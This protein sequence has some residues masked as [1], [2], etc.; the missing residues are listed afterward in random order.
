[1]LIYQEFLALNTNEELA[2]FNPRERLR[3]AVHEIIIRLKDQ[4]II[5]F[6]EM[7]RI[8][9]EEFKID[10]T[11]EILKNIFDRWDSFNNPD[12]SIFKKSDKNWMDVWVFQGHVK[13]KIKD[14]QIFGKHRKKDYTPPNYKNGEYSGGRYERGV[15]IPNKRPGYHND[16]YY[17]DYYGD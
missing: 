14:K 8:L 6:K 12:Y 16:N 5:K 9:R 11:E 3:Y 1:M 15:W 17:G 7:S 13:R 4:E 10:I 2:S